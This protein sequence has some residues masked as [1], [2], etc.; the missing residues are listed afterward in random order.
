MRVL[1]VEDP[2]LTTALT[3]VLR[4][5]GYEVIHRESVDESRLLLGQTDVDAAVID[6]G[7]KGGGRKFWQELEASEAYR[8][9]VILLAGDPATLGPLR[10]SPR[11]YEK[12][13]GYGELLDELAECPPRPT[14]SR[15]PDT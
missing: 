14:S 3:L 2:S 12:P 10:G 4:Q 15:S 13:F 9:R 11:V 8:G 6:C 1:I 5:A 7:S